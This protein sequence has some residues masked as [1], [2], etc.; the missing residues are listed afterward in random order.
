MASKVD[1]FA[2]WL[3]PLGRVQAAEAEQYR[4][5]IEMYDPPITLDVGRAESWL[6]ER[7]WRHVQRDKRYLRRC[8]GRHAYEALR[9][10]RQNLVDQG[11]EMNEV[12][13][14]VDRDADEAYLILLIKRPAAQTARIADPTLT[15]DNRL[16]LAVA[17]ALR[18]RWQPGVAHKM[19]FGI[20]KQRRDLKIGILLY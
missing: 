19:V 6:G 14:D 2:V 3:Q 16:A 1:E 4:L 9:Q 12:S 5:H 18:P 10:I 17:T 8:M 20:A 13:C 11:F 7:A 15:D